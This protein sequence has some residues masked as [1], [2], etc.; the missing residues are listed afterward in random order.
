MSDH[1]PTFKPSPTRR[2]LY[3]RLTPLAWALI[4]VGGLTAFLSIAGVVL[5]LGGCG[6]RASDEPWW[7]PTPT[8]PPTATPVLPM[9]TPTAWYEGM[10]SPTPEP[11]VAFPAWW[12]DQMTQDEDGNWRPPEEVAE[13]VRQ[14][15]QECDQELYSQYL[16]ETKPPDLDGYVQEVIPICTTG[17]R[18]ESDLDYVRNVRDRINVILWAEWENGCIYQVQEW[19]ED[20]LECTLGQTCSNGTAYHYDADGRLVESKHKDHSGLILY[21]M[22]Y[23]SADGR[24]KIARFIRWIPP[25]RQ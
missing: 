23:D 1:R 22:Q 10:V 18:M 15:F 13:M 20:G 6:N 16:I 9:P 12:A 25:A 5:A 24:W 14:H 2:P 19:S 3:Q 8:T 21:R 11:T 4:G 17:D 7:T